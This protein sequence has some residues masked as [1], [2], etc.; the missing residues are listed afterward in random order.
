MCNA[1][2]V[3]CFY[4]IFFFTLCKWGTVHGVILGQ[5]SADC[6]YNN[7]FYTPCTQLLHLWPFWSFCFLLHGEQNRQIGT[8]MEPRDLKQKKSWGLMCDFGNKTVYKQRKKCGFVL[9]T[10]CFIL[11]SQNCMHACFYCPICTGT[12]SN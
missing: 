4:S 5:F 8:Q 9:Y 11:Y 6:R 12:C 2:S 10:E 7:S 3:L 1:P